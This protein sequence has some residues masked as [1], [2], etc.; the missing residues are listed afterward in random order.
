M[1]EKTIDA[2][3]LACPKPVL[4]TREA[5]LAGDATRLRVLIDNMASC[6]NVT[7]MVDSLG[8]QARIDKRGE[9][10]IHLVVD[11]AATTRTSAFPGGDATLHRASSDD[12]APQHGVSPKETAFPHRA[13]PQDSTTAQNAAEGAPAQT[14]CRAASRNVVLISSDRFGEG[15][16]E[17]GSVLMRAFIK[18]LKE[19]VPT[20]ETI[21]FI[22]AGVRL[23]TEDSA[24]IQ[25]IREL[26]ESGMQVFSC[27][28]CLD[29]FHLKEKLVVGKVTNMFEVVSH[30]SA[31]DRVIRP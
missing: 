9:D 31:A 8:H 21:F 25:D 20:P 12:A 30:L 4:L 23:T 27:G 28:T 15:D 7:R 29:F 24:L 16:D 26:E 11:V 3:G 17:L 13:S 5:L 2:R 14:A 19:V 1:D 18:T 10:E 6:E 22:N